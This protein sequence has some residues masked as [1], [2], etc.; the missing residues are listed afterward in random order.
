MQIGNRFSGTQKLLA[1]KSILGACQKM[2]F[3][4]ET[5]TTIAMSLMH[6]S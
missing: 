3:I 1:G 5:D 4:M 2:V 6:R